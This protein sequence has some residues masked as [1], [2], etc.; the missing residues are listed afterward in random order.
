VPKVQLAESPHEMAAGSVACGSSAVPVVTAVDIKA[1]SSARA[2]HLTSCL[3]FI[4]NSPFWDLR[5]SCPH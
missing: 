1:N 3:L 5:L 2:T 4:P